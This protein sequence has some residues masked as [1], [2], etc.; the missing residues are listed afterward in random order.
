V[1]VFLKNNG[2][3]IGLYLLLLI[4]ASYF[5]LAFD[6]VGINVYVNQYV[7]NRYLNAFFYFVTYL[8]DGRI[9]TLIL[10]AIILYNVRT[11]IYATFSFLSSALVAAIL[12]YTY[13]D[14]E[15]RPFYVYQWIEKHHPITYVEG[16]DLHIHNSFPSGHATQAFAIF[17]CLA[18]L[19]RRPFF[20]VF[21]FVV[22]VITAFSRVYLSQHWLIDI[23]AGSLI[24]TVTALSYYYVFIY[25]NRFSKLDRSLQDFNRR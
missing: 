19:S 24:G 10:I 7:G 25:R 2:L 1:K 12:K 11:G 22:A 3:V 6:K 23:T 5:I 17:M 20:A 14:D 15:N 4:V 13:F 9:A 21:F 18:F 16:V 8:G